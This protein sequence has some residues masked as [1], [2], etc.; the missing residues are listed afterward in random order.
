MSTTCRRDSTV[1]HPAGPLSRGSVGGRAPDPP[2]DPVRPLRASGPAPARPPDRRA[3]RRLPGARA[4]PPLG[5]RLPAARRLALR[6]VRRLLPQ[7][8]DRVLA[9][10]AAAV[11]AAAG[12]GVRATG[13][14]EEAAAPSVARGRLAHARSRASGD[15]AA[16]RLTRRLRPLAGRPA[17]LPE[18]RPSTAPTALRRLRSAPDGRTLDYRGTLHLGNTALWVQW[19]S[20]KRSAIGC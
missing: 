1:R 4:A 19:C 3:R 5:R 15:R 6:A 14:T 16:G 17:A 11:V 10:A 9:P 13:D 8:P 18:L 12:N 20:R 7:R 2:G